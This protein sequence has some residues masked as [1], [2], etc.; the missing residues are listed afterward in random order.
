MFKLLGWA[1]RFSLLAIGVLA[2][3][4]LIKWDGKTVSD[5]VQSTMSQVE[6]TSAGQTVREW[7][8]RLAEDAEHETK[9]ARKSAERAAQRAAK[10]AIR[11]VEE[12]SDDLLGSERAKLRALIRELNN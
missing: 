12:E 10:E 7:A 8:E 1:F 2:A 3:G 6:K 5:R 4:H 9:K 11:K